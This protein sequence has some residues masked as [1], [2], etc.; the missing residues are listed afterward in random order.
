MPEPEQLRRSK[1]FHKIV[2]NDY[3]ENNTGDIFSE[4]VVIINNLNAK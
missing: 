4:K 1:L 3:L 2:Q